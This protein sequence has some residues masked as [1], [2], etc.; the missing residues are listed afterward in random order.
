MG[1][2]LTSAIGGLGLSF[3]SYIIGRAILNLSLFREDSGRNGILSSL[4]VYIS[5]AFFIVGLPAAVAVH[6]VQS[7]PKKRIYNAA[8]KEERESMEK[9]CQ[10]DIK[11]AVQKEH[12]R[13]VQ[14]YSELM[15]ETKRK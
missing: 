8:R 6:L 14:Y 2:E 1:S 15:R 11:A 7:Y 9:I 12:D 13:L 5:V 10:A 4:L 3:I